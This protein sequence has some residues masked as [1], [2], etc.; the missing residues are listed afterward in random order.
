VLDKT[1]TTNEDTSYTVQTADF[2][3][4]TATTRPPNALQAVKIT[5]LPGAGSLKNNGAAVAVNDEISASD[6]AAGKLTFTPAATPT[7]NNYAHFDF[8]VPDSG[9]TANSGVDLDQIANTITV[10]VTPVNDAPVLDF[11]GNAQPDRHRRRGSGNGG[12]SIA[13]LIASGGAGYVTDVDSGALKGNRDHR[14]RHHQWGM[15]V[16]DERRH[17]VVRPGAV[18]GANARLLEA[19]H[20]QDP[21][22]PS[23]ALPGPRPAITFRAWTAR[24]AATA[25]RTTTSPNAAPRLSARPPTRPPSSSRACRDGQRSCSR[26]AS[27]QRRHVVHRSRDRQRDTGAPAGSG[28]HGHVH[29]T[30]GTGT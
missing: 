2:G 27:W 9:G 8:Q 18:T 28:R 17:D 19:R 4:A 1:V 24:A 23:S 10:D 26:Q 25:D 20:D 3:S 12:T 7:G 21:L 13:D 11:G 30:S 16:L 14:R 15:A 22:R 5:T 29:N 6:I